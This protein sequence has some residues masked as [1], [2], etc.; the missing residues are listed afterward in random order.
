M[1]IGI[2]Y[3][4]RSFLLSASFGAPNDCSSPEAAD[5]L[6]CINRGRDANV[7]AAATRDP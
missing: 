1:V 7:V 3:Q 2:K 4:A 5:F 6:L